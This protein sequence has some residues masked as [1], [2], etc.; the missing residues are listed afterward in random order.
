MALDVREL[1]FRASGISLETLL[2]QQ[3][4]QI[5]APPPNPAEPDVQLHED[6]YQEINLADNADLDLREQQIASLRRNLEALLR[7]DGDHIPVIPT[8]A[9][10]AAQETVQLYV[11]PMVDD[12]DDTEAEEDDIP[13][14][15]A[16]PDDEEFEW[17]PLQEDDDLVGM[18]PASQQ[19]DQQQEAGEQTLPQPMSGVT[20]PGAEESLASEAAQEEAS[21][22]QEQPPFQ[23]QRAPRIGVRRSW[24]LERET[25]RRLRE[26]RDTACQAICSIKRKLREVAEA[27]DLPQQMEL[28]EWTAMYKPILGGFKGFLQSRPDQFE[29]V[30]VAG[31][32]GAEEDEVA[33]ML[34]E[35]ARKLVDNPPLPWFLRDQQGDSND[36]AGSR[37]VR[38]RRPHWAAELS[39]PLPPLVKSAV[40]WIE[41]GDTSTS[42]SSKSR[43]PAGDVAAAVPPPAEPPQSCQELLWNLHRVLV[44]LG[45]PIP[46]DEVMEEYRNYHG[47]ECNIGSYLVI[48]HGLED[49]FRRIPHVVL[50][51][52]QPSS[53]ITLVRA[54]QTVNTP[55]EKFMYVDREFKRR[56]QD[57]RAKEGQQAASPATSTA[58]TAAATPSV[59]ERQSVTPVP[60]SRARLPQPLARASAE[61]ANVTPKAPRPSTA[62]APSSTAS[63]QP[64]PVWSSLTSRPSWSSGGRREPRKRPLWADELSKP[65][66][67]LTKSVV[68]EI[69]SSERVGSLHAAK[70][71]EEEEQEVSEPTL[72]DPFA[73]DFPEAKEEKDVA[74][75]G[76][77]T[78]D[79]YFTYVADKKEEEE[80]ETNAG[81][82]EEDDDDDALPCFEDTHGLN[83]Q[84]EVPPSRPAA[85]S[86]PVPWRSLAPEA[87]P[88]RIAPLHWPA[89][90][91][92]SQRAF[93]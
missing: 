18:P 78:D 91:P 80:V 9:L 39:K 28:P 4:Q 85:H 3:Q 59:G 23:Q 31:E 62:P 75:P 36:A 29:V 68:N 66:P 53:G 64:P 10:Q 51:L 54:R 13:E 40:N 61:V 82:E 70:Q 14:A 47:H 16:M 87:P 45:K 81:V 5:A 27:D 63:R 7:P 42:H 56:L 26:K 11:E 52:P 86:G 50:L 24:E 57:L 72:A 34:A 8:D 74:S 41:G 17:V 71:E 44:A 32:D 88:A 48:R 90:R 83:L 89:S 46:V 25:K 60:K 79:V 35:G 21:Q 49:T 33:I 1:G 12:G 76:I 84:A 93:R 30:T 58:A 22:T 37:R 67:R 43:P 65:L 73:A 38:A 92:P 77:P 19:V 6:P 69:E 2:R 55:K 20:G 15:P